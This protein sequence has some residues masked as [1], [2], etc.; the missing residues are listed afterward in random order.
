[1]KL[2][3]YEAAR[4]A[5]AEAK[6][7]DEVKSIRDKAIAMKV[8]AK[9]SR[10]PDLIGYSTEILKRATRR[11]GE[12][13]AVQPKATGTKG[14][15][16]GRRSSGGAIKTPPDNIAS[17]LADA[18]IDKNLA[19]RA[20]EAANMP[21]DKFEADIEKAKRNATAAAEGNKEVIAAARA[22]RHDTR[23][24]QRKE[25]ETQWAG[26][27]LALPTKHYGVIYADPEWQF[28]FYSEKGKTNS[29]ADNHYDTSPLE[30]IKAR[31]VVSISAKDCVLFLW[32]TSPMMPHA[33]EVMLAWG[34]EYKSQC[35]WRKSKAGTGYWFRNQHELLLVGTR[36]K[37]VAPADG[38][39]FPSI[40][41]APVT[42]HSEKPLVFY[43]VIERYFQNVPKVELNARA[44]RKGWDSWG[45]EAPS[46]AA[47]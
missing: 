32:A 40:I 35:I 26:K 46:E 21:E 7:V 16:K 31:D 25:R 14:Q 28:K 9:Q 2:V 30:E 15:L 12:L 41:D 23:Q 24:K 13:M 42:K 29:S 34:F 33:L 8:Y 37:V 47:E 39:Q 44:G 19:K 27:V 17:T 10:D 20:R 4:K 18:G 43:E 1:M 6:R 5:L 38:M 45:H 3:K 11:L 22:E 36:G